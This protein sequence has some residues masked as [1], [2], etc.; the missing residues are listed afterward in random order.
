MCGSKH[1]GDSDKKGHSNFFNGGQKLSEK[2]LLIFFKFHAG[3]GPVVLLCPV[4]PLSRIICCS[5]HGDEC[6]SKENR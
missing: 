2:L 6:Y 5:H 4:S 3:M 1:A